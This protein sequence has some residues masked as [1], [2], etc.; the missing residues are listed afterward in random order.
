MVLVR[1]GASALTRAKA[2]AVLPDIV[3]AASVQT[4]AYEK[5]RKLLAVYESS[6]V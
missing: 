1:F 4:P 2:A 6:F 5:A 3:R